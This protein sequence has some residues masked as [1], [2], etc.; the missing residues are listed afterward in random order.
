[1]TEESP[2]EKVSAIVQDKNLIESVLYL[3]K[4]NL[5]PEN[6]STVKYETVQEAEEEKCEEVL[7]VVKEKVNNLKQEISELQKAGYNLHLE[8]IKLLEVPLKT[9]VWLATRSVH[10]LEIIFNLIFDVQK[11]TKPFREEFNKKLAEKEMLE[12]EA[13]AKEKSKA[14]LVSGK[15]EKANP[16]ANSKEPQISKES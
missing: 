16:V 6:K 9:R 14:K 8:T 3:K 13:A 4:N 5:L 11:I 7:Y 10:D 15:K 2:K 1:M 12:K